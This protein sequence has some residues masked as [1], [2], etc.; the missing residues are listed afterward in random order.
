M[1]NRV[2]DVKLAIFLNWEAVKLNERRVREKE[3]DEW[4]GY[5]IPMVG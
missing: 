2:R 4:R 1:Q 5:F 3:R